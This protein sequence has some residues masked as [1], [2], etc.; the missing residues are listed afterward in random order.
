MYTSLGFPWGT[1]NAYSNLGVLYYARG[2]WPQAVENLQRAYVLRRDNGYLPEQAVTLKNL[3]LVRLAMGDHTQAQEDLGASLEISRRL[4]D[5]F[6]IVCAQL[7]L[8]LLAVTQNRFKD[9]AAHLEIAMDLLDGAVGDEAI[10]AHWL[11]ALIQAENGD[12]QAGL[13]SAEQALQMAKDA[14]ISEQD[15]ECLRVLGALRARVGEYSQAEALFH[16][17]ISLSSQRNDA[18][19]KGL[20]LLALGQMGQYLARPGSPGSAEWRAKA[21]ATLDQ[22]VKEFESLG[23]AHDLELAQAA[24]HQLEAEAGPHG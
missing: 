4:G 19:Q 11:L 21:Q 12:L 24:L 9:A 13:K 15:T 10:Q 14:G 16:E 1:A 20:A 22:A 7:G 18:Y 6:G 23:A 8:T 3:G 17:S 2:M 5:N